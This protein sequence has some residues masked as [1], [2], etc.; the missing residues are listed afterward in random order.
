MSAL[1]SPWSRLKGVVGMLYAGWLPFT[2][3]HVEPVDLHRRTA[4]VLG[5]N[6]GIG[7]ECG[8]NLARYG[9][10]VWILCRDAA[11][12]EA[13]RA[14][15]AETSGNADIVVAV[16]DFG[17]LATRERRGGVRDGM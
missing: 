8:L 5:A 17:S 7:Y 6:V 3:L 12:A 16:V 2:K 13:A 4:L 1:A 15:L 11:K 10:P 9:S 14:K